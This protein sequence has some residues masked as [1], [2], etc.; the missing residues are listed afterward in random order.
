MRER[1]ILSPILLNL[2]FECIFR[3][4]LNDVEEGISINGIRLNNLWCT[5]YIIVFADNVE[6]LQVLM[7]R[8]TVEAVNTRYELDINTNK[9]KLMIINN[10][11]TLSEV[12]WVLIK[13][14]PL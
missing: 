13:L 7:D 2:Y 10:K 4:A 8:I 12:T 11:K 5:D 3:E 14:A 1:C 6:G 9:T